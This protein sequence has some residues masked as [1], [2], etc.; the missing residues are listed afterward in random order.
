[1]IY[2]VGVQNKNFII[3]N[4]NVIIEY[5]W[6]DYRVYNH[7]F[8]VN[9]FY[10]YGYPLGFWA[11][12]HAEQLYFQYNIK[13]NKTKFI[14]EL[15]QS[16]RGVIPIDYNDILVERYT[17]VSE[18]KNIYS[19]SI[20][21]PFKDILLLKFGYSYISWEN[22]GFEPSESDMN[23]LNDIIKNNYFISANYSFK[24]ISI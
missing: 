23:N 1:M 11:G 12:P 10:S 7:K 17:N 9:D 4:S 5:V 8:D 24:S 2:Q 15:S 19:I 13:S 20:E 18:S 22:S 6:S 14:I 16:E 3:N 21:H